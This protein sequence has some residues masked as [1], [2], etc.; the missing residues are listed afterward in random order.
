MGDRDLY[1]P[2]AAHRNRLAQILQG[3]DRGTHTVVRLPGHNHLL[4]LAP[5][6]LPAEYPRINHAVSP[7]ALE[8]VEDW[9][10]TRVFR[11]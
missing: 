5:T 11:R 6:G 7:L 4:Q 3:R 9:V 2:P 10:L 1:F 8:T